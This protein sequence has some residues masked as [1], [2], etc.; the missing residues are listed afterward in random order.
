MGYRSLATKT[1]REFSSDLKEELFTTRGTMYKIFEGALMESIF[2]QLHQA[3]VDRSRKRA[4]AAGG[5][6]DRLCDVTVK[7][8]KQ[9]GYNATAE[10]IMIRTRRSIDS[11]KPGK[12]TRFGYKPF[13]QDQFYKISGTKIK[14]GSKV[15]YLEFAEQP[16]RC[17]PSGRPILTQGLIDHV[18]RQG[19]RVATGKVIKEIR[20]RYKGK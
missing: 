7:I 1:V 4:N 19:V 3:Y 14:F 20:R 2:K 12:S 11:F 13:N 18:I 10:L 16:T 17:A 5:T 8:K 6:W 15:K 9:L